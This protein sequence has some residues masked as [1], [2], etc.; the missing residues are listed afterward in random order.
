MLEGHIPSVHHCSHELVGQVERPCYGQLP[1]KRQE[2]L[3]LGLAGLAASAEPVAPP[4]PPAALVGLVC[5]GGH[6]GRAH[7]FLAPLPPLEQAGQVEGP[8]HGQGL[9]ERQELCLLGLAGLVAG[10]EPVAPP[11]THP[12]RLPP[13]V[14]ADRAWGGGHVGRAHPFLAPHLSLFQAGQ[15]EL[16]RTHC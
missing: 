4:L 9:V 7:A 2:L 5:V 11:C 6:V 16:Q 10:A 3:F 12:S 1:V 13:A 8:R 15:V 14:L